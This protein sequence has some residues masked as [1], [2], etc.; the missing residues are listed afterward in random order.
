MDKVDFP[1]GMTPPQGIRPRITEE[2]DTENAIDREDAD[3]HR[4]GKKQETDLPE[5]DD[6]YEDLS[7]VSIALLRGF[8]E[9]LVDI[10]HKVQDV[11][12]TAPPSSYAMQAYQSAGAQ[13]PEAPPAPSVA[14][15][16][17][18]LGFTRLDVAAEG[19]D[20]SEIV[21][22]LTQLE[23]LETAGVHYVSIERST[24]FLQS[25]RDAITRLT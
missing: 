23:R 4:R 5:F 3:R 13:A 8:L 9:N 12:R 15:D 2:N 21:L 20:K 7:E 16:T 11:R 22:I 24:S 25:I 14:E 19:L 6:V 10:K 18:V 17:E 1:R